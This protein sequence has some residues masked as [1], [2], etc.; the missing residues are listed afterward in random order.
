MGVDKI[1]AYTQRIHRRAVIKK[2]K[3]V[4]VTCRQQAKELAGD[5][6]T[7]GKLTGLSLEDFWTWAKKDT[8]GYDG[9]DYISQDKCVDFERELWFELGKC[10]WINHWS[11][12]QEHIK[13]V[14]ND[15]LKPLKVKI[16]RYDERV[17]EMRDLAKY[18]HPP[19]IKGA[20]TMVDNWNVCN[21]ELTASDIRLEIKDGL[22]KSMRDE[23]DDHSEDYFS[24][25]SEYWCGL[26]STFEVK[27]E[28]KMAVTQIKKIVSARE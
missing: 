5:E 15:I 6:W 23:L 13:Y 26:L 20:S 4:L 2:Q 18:L 1:L 21:Q 24:L 14:C 7:L 16:L 3:E 25:T 10:M 19:S 12:Y 28:I 8:T 9:H 17:R 27:D 22:P 11:V